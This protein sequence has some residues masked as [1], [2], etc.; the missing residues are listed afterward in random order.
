MFRALSSSKHSVSGHQSCFSQP[1]KA[2]TEPPRRAVV[3]AQVR[4][5]MSKASPPEDTFPK[6][7]VGRGIWGE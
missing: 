5:V 1:S 7:L 6:G 2:F 4:I 3:R